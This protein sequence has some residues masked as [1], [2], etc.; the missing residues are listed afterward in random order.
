MA[1]NSTTGVFLIHARPGINFGPRSPP[2]QVTFEE[3]IPK[4]SGPPSKVSRATAKVQVTD[5]SAAK[6]MTAGRLSREAPKSEAPLEVCENLGDKL[7]QLK[8]FKLDHLPANFPYLKK[9][10]VATKVNR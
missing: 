8:Q 5:P 7:G 4:D 10:W 6:A 2:V 3:R 9:E 1:A